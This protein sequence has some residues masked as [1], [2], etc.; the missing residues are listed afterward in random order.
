MN[1]ATA[2]PPPTT[3]N[4]PININKRMMGVNHHFFLSV[5]NLKR[6][7]RKSIDIV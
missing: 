6:S 4:I 5:M 2:E 3:I 1:G 7:F